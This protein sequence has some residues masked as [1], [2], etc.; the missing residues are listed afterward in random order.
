MQVV[1]GAACGA[2][3]GMAFGKDPY[4]FGM[5]N[6]SLGKLGMLVIRLLKALAAPLILVAI[7]DAFVRTHF[8]AR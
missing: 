7:V 1:L 6:E 3:L 2:A 4:F 8:S 5:G